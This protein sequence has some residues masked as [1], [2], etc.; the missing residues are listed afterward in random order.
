MDGNKKEASAQM[1]RMSRDGWRDLLE[2]IRMTETRAYFS[3][4]ARAGGRKPRRPT[5]PRAAPLRDTEGVGRIH[6]RGK[7]DLLADFSEARLGGVL[8]NPAKEKKACGKSGRT[9]KL[10]TGKLE[11]SLETV[12]EVEVTKAVM[13]LSKKKAAGA[14]DLV[15]EMLCYMSCLNKPIA[16]LFNMMLRTGRFPYQMLQ[17]AMIPPGRPRKG[18]ET[19]GAKR[20]ISLNPVISITLEAVVLNRLLVKYE[21]RLN[22]HQYAHRR[23]R[24]AEMHL[25]DFSDCIRESRDKGCY[26][27]AAS[28]DVAP[29]FDANS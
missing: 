8:A 18:P 11:G 2:N 19:C 29:A 25:L 6:A 10:N 27:Y 23:D 20:P 21:G 14:D 15:A 28:I 22:M 5:V 1:S 13:G 17:V 7:C 9:G 12:R 24:G 4:L 26:I 16:C 3:Y